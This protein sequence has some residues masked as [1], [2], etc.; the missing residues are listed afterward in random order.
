MPMVLRK[1]ACAPVAVLKLPPVLVA[2][3]VLLAQKHRL[4][5]GSFKAFPAVSKRSDF[6]HR[7]REHLCVCRK[8]AYL[9]V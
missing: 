8:P 9:F 4:D 7:H 6:N 3:C 1:S 2:D 5:A